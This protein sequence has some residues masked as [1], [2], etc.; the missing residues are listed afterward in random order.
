MTS[1]LHVDHWCFP[2]TTLIHL[3]FYVWEE[4]LMSYERLYLDW[5]LTLS[6][7]Q[8]KRMS[9]TKIYAHPLVRV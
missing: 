2:T 8:D 3:L 1:K 4:T 9:D 5:T 7:K 6:D